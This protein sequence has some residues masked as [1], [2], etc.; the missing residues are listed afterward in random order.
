MIHRIYSWI[1]GNFPQG[2]GDPGLALLR[3]MVNQALPLPEVHSDRSWDFFLSDFLVSLPC[4]CHLA[5][6][7]CTGRDSQTI[8]W[9]NGN[10]FTHHTVSV[11]AGS[12]CPLSDANA[13]GL[14]YSTLDQPLFQLLTSLSSTTVESRLAN[15]PISYI[16]LDE[17]L[18]L[19]RR[20]PL[21][22]PE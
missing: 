7:F 2:P 17:Q 4:I 20:I 18:Q 14:L 16:L 8:C 5:T 1:C 11:S 22:E 9:Q 12:V 21:S 10:D 3:Q 19:C 6:I 13:C 15:T